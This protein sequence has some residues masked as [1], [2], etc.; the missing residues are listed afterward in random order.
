MQDRIWEPGTEDGFLQLC[1]ELYERQFRLN[2]VYR[3]YCS[4]LGRYGVTLESLSE[5]V[6]LPISFFKTHAVLDA[7][8]GARLTF[9]SSGTTGSERSSHQ[10]AS[11]ELY[12]RSFL[13][14]FKRSFGDPSRCCILGLLPSYLEKGDSSLVYMVDRL[15][16]LSGDSRS[17]FWLYDLSGLA[18][19]LEELKREGKP[20]VLFG[21][22][23]ALLDF[24]EQHPMDLSG[25]HIVETG[26]MKGR[27]RE[28]TRQE[29]HAA[30]KEAFHLDRV[31]SEYGMTELLSQAYTRGGE[32]FYPPPWMRI[33]TREVQDPFTQAAEG[34]TGGINVIDLA[35][36]YSCP[37]IET[38]D[39]G[40]AYPD[41]SF[42]ILG[43]FDHSDVRGCNLLVV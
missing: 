36:M 19:L 25:M 39:L 34:R 42:E 33:T 26:G 22:T 41:G 20:V 35:N 1:R 37:F 2:P 12:E 3:S 21:V 27:R 40:R 4:H 24:A 13:Q 28:I 7:S 17:G 15:I 5:L 30:L 14:S 23:F 31:Y 32:R 38:Q 16:R 43:R 8:Q 11:P 10:I 9:H 18:R 29:L 6:Y